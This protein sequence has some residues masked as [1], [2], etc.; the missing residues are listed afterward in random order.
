MKEKINVAVI[1][2]GFGAL[3][4][5]P[6]YHLN[7]KYN[8][9]GVYGRNI[10]KASS[11]AKEY[12]IKVYKSKEE[13][14]LDSTVDMVSISSIVSEHIS[15]VKMFLNKKYIVLEKPMSINFEDANILKLLCEE[16]GIKTAICHEHKYDPSWKYVKYLITSK[17]YGSMRCIYFNYSFTYW[18]S[19]RSARKFDWFSLKQYGGGII[20]GHL[21]HVLDLIL[22]LDNAGIKEI[23]GN[24]YIEVKEHYDAN[25]EVQKQTA[26]DTVFASAM[27]YSGVPVYI[28]LSA[29]RFETYKKVTI[30]T[31]KAKITIC[32][33]NEIKITNR[34][35]EVIESD[36]PSD[37]IIKD[38]G[39][40]SRLNSFM[41]FLDEFYMGYIENKETSITDFN[42]GCIIQKLI[43]KIKVYEDE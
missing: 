3:V 13:I 21:S 31:E 24:G 26:E 4:H 32:G 41:I 43:D 6:A 40:D 8:L 33:Q 39:K 18:N 37:Y 9:V 35:G 38:Y 5:I 12:G 11:V 22:Y 42:K 14:A 25:G 20:G 23:N 30:Y 17:Q 10:D 34:S 7:D 19:E 29:S 15:D 2:T 27:T 16:N 1:G 28:D 36:I